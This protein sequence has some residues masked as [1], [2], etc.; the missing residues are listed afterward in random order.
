[1][2]KKKP[3]DEIVKLEKEIKDLKSINRSLQRQVKTRLRKYKPESNQ[4]DI[5]KEEYDSKI[6]CNKCGK[7][8]KQLV[9]LGP[10]Q[11]ITC[12]VCDYKETLKPDVK[13]EEI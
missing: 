1:M 7:G 11:L 8:N 10:R 6:K 3:D 9:D 2:S 5:I 4:E 13:K 12:T